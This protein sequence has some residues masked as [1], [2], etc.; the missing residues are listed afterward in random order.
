MISHHCPICYT[1]VMEFIGEQESFGS[2]LILAHRIDEKDIETKSEPSI[3]VHRCSRCK[4]LS[5]TLNQAF[6]ESL[7][8]HKNCYHKEKLKMLT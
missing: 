6:E 1:G 7:K 2:E 3:L 5:F 4:N 8:H